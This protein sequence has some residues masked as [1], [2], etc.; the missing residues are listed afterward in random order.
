MKLH[1]RIQR[2]DRRFGPPPLKNHKIYGFLAIQVRIPSKIAA[3][4][5]AFNV[6]HSSAC[7]RNAILWRFAG[8]PMVARLKWTWILPPLIN[9][10]KKLSKLDPFL[11]SRVNYVRRQFNF[12]RVGSHKLHACADPEHFVRGGSERGPKCH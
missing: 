3:A 12:N 9:F 8:G 4:K 10:K 2:G 11:D 7:Q 1:L 5:P 6:G